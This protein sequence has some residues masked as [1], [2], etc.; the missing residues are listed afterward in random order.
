MAGT[1][2]R[3]FEEPATIASARRPASPYARRLARERGLAL[4]R[5][6]GSGPGGRIVAADVEAFV[7]AEVARAA[8]SPA[9]VAQISAFG[10]DIDLGRLTQLL[11]DLA[12]AGNPLT[13]DALLV[14]AGAQALEALPGIVPDR[15]AVVVALE[16]SGR[17]EADIA[18]R[19]AQLGLATALQTRLAAGAGDGG[20]DVLLSIRRFDVGG[21]RALAMPLR[22]GTPLRFVLSADRD[23]VAEGLLSFDAGRVDE[24]DA[25]ALLGRLRD[26][27]ETPLR[28]LA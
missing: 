10:V 27:L 28:L 24:D 14:R 2:T 16:R 8:T 21:I 17:G 22:G 23:G 4:E 5:I 12:A 3:S 9:A 20:A 15:T 1:P 25:A 18:I 26:G 19:D 11:S 7:P 6:T 13:L